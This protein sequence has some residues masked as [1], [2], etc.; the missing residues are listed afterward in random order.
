MSERP[1]ITAATVIRAI[2]D[3]GSR[4]S[5][6]T[7][8]EIADYLKADEDD[9]RLHLRQ[10]RSQRLYVDRSRNRRRVWMPWSAP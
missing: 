3:L 7:P 4:G 8:A 9:V 6:P 10:L 1:E 5:W 2:N